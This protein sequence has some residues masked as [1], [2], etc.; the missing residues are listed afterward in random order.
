MLAAGGQAVYIPCPI[1][2]AHE[3]ITDHSEE[4]GGYFQLEDIGLL[5][6]LVERLSRR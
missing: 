2:W 5:P 3:M 1:N 6:A 4:Q